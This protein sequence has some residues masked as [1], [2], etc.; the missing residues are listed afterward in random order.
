MCIRDRTLSRLE[1][2]GGTNYEYFF[3]EALT[4]EIDQYT[5]SFAELIEEQENG[6]GRD[7]DLEALS[8][9]DLPGLEYTDHIFTPGK[10]EKLH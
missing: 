6:Q 10:P 7:A 3:E 2:L 5:M 8:D 1:R 4:F 9:T